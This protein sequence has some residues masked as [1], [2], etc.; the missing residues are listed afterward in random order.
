MPETKFY[1]T[2]E[3]LEKIKKE[4]DR[5]VEFKKLKTKGDVPSIWESEDVNPDYLAFQEDMSLL[6]TRLVEY[7][8]VLKNIELIRVPE[9][10]KRSQVSLG[11]TVTVDLGGEVDEFTI[12]GTLEA[13]PLAKKISNESPLGHGLLGAKVGDTVKIKTALIN[14]DCKILKIIYY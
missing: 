2:K 10:E 4:Y 13:N 9:K 5:L 7:E 8:N 12:V 14:H 6:E 1:L 3:G 11:A